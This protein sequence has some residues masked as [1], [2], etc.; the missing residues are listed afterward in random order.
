MSQR[1]LFLLGLSGMFFLAGC[2]HKP[3]PA[4]PPVPE[5]SVS[6]PIERDVTDYEDFTGRTDAVYSVDIRARVTGYLVKVNFKD[7]ELVK[8]DDVLYEIDPRPYQAE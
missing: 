1:C 7:G 5:V 6:V 4:A 2:A 3:P 8:A